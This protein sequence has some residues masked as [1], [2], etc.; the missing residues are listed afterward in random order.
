MREP[1]AANDD[2]PQQQQVSA[3]TLADQA[4]SSAIAG[5]VTRLCTHP[6]DTIKAR[7]QAASQPESRHNTI[8]EIWRHSSWRSLYRG[9]SVALVGGTP[10]TVLY[11]TAYE[12]L[13][14]QQPQD[15]HDSSSTS[16]S[17]SSSSFA[18]HFLAGLTAEALACSIYVPVDVLKE[19]LQVGMYPTLAVAL[20]TI[21][22]NDNEGP[23]KRPWRTLYRGYWATLASFG[24]YSAFYFLFYEESKRLV[25][26]TNLQKS[27]H[28]H[29]HHQQL[30]FWWILA[31][32]AGSGAAASF[33]TSPLD[34]VKL[35][36]QLKNSQDIPRLP[37]PQQ[38]QQSPPPPLP[39][40]GGVLYELS[41]IYRTAGFRGL[42]RGAGARVL[43]FVP[44]TTIAMTTYET[45]RGSFFAV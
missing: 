9:L 33:I 18:T 17:T 36:L 28:H 3:H 12:Q 41:L 25:R 40:G 39:G 23:A 24:P 27:N 34:L 21:F 16:S 32:S 26:E 20:A 15:D 2:G 13:K 35:R 44:A 42:F 19:R 11:L 4:L 1:A 5:I 10:G 43:H 7:L 8:Q 31:C 30:S 22:S 45:C 14:G 37:L 29:P 38:Q 6:L